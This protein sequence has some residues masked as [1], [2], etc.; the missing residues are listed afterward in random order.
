[1]QDDLR[2]SAHELVAAPS[3]RIPGGRDAYRPQHE[4]DAL[5][6]A[7]LLDQLQRL[8]LVDVAV[9]HRGY[10][11]EGRWAVDD[12]RNLALD[13]D[14]VGAVVDGERRARVTSQV[15]R[16]T[17]ADARVDHDL[18][19][20]QLVPDECLMRTAVGIDRG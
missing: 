8:R 11:R 16:P 2:S 10:F 4:G 7:P 19:P 20:A 18:V 3:G 15:G 6:T 12:R 13:G 17:P 14:T 9:R 1:M 5:L